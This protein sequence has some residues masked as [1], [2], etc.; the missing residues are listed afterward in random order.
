MP[1]R[2]RARRRPRSRRRRRR[3]HPAEH[4]GPSG[5][6][7]PAAVDTAR[8]RART[9]AGARARRRPW[10]ARPARRAA[11]RSCSSSRTCIAPMPR[12][13]RWS[14][15]SPGS[16]PTSGWRSSSRTSRTSSP[17]T[18]RGPAPSRRSRRP[19]GPWSGSRCRSLDRDELAALIEGIEGERAS[20]SLLLLV[21]ERSGGSPLVAEEL[22]AA[23]RELPTASLTGSLDELVMRRLASARWSAAGSCA[24]SP[25]RAG[26]S[27]ADHLAAVAAAFEV[28]TDRPAPRSVSGPRRGDGVLDADLRAGLAE[29][30]EHGFLVEHDGA[31]GFRHEL[32]RGGRR[33]ATCCPSPSPAT[34]PRS[35]P[36]LPT[37]RGRR[38]PL[39]RGPRRGGA[40]EAAIAAAELA[41]ERH[42]PADELEALELALALSDRGK[43]HDR[44]TAARSARRPSA[45]P[46]G[47]SSRTGRPSRL[48]R[49]GGPRR[50]TAYLE[51]A[52][53]ALDARRDRVRVGLLYDRLAHVRRAAGDPAGARSPPAAGRR[54]RPPRPEPRAGDGRRDARPAP[55]STAS[56]P[57]AQRL[58]REAIKVARACDPVARDQEIHA[59]TTL[60]VAIAWGRDPN[61]RDRAAAR[62]RAGGARDRRPGRALPRHRQPDDRARPR[63][64]AGGGGR[65]RVSRASRTRSGPGSRRSTATSW[66]ATWPNR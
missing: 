44:T 1:S 24:C 8:G 39:A 9:P 56:S 36:V 63:R 49:S 32:D 64:P 62:G 11:A 18:T 13:A 16:R 7:R 14:P 58:A 65:G 66:P 54:P 6:D 4:R 34:T 22:L 43:G 47:P 25:R 12:H 59:T 5:P 3:P 50:A 15:S 42:A 55:C 31:V 10:H 2:R 27:T 46:T 17:A 48:S 26:R 19:R 20:A 37:T 41:A 45:P 52:I 60:G 28:E 23:R 35:P 21:A 51:S 29:G 38:A 40:R 33:A 30:I 53:G 61:A 57:T